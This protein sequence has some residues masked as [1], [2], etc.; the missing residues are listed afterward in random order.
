M[1]NEFEQISLKQGFMKHNGGVF[2]ETF[3]KQNMNLNLQLIKII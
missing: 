2:L 3:Q 1:L